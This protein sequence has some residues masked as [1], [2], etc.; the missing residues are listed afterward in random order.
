MPLSSICTFSGPPK[1]AYSDTGLTQT[2]PQI[3][4]FSS[5]V[6]DGSVDFVMIPETD[7]LPMFSPDVTDYSTDFF[8]DWV[9]G[10]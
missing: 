7:L 4:V 5:D 6:A 9:L 3:I 10:L 1:P 2:L 8:I